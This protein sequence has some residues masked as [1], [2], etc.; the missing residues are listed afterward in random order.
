MV[1]PEY[2]VEGR[3]INYTHV[4][5]AVAY[6]FASLS[7]KTS[8]I[9]LSSLTSYCAMNDI[10]YR[11]HTVV[12]CTR[13]VRL[14]DPCLVAEVHI[15]RILREQQIRALLQLRTLLIHPVCRNVVLACCPRRIVGWPTECRVPLIQLDIFSG[16]LTLGELQYL[17]E[18]NTYH[19]G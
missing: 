2:W 17:Q 10:M 15:V 14:Y 6:R 16:S 12:V 9:R 13:V 7:I 18:T 19:R 5:K 11:F 3:I 8:A 1:K 4:T